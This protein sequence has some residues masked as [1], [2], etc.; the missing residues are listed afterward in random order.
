MTRPN[1]HGTA[2]AAK[3]AADSKEMVYTPQGSS[4]EIKLT[5]GIVQS[6]CCARTK[7]GAVATQADALKFMMLCQA[8]GLNPFEGDAYLV[9]YDGKNG[10]EFSMITAHQAF[11][12][13]AECHPEYDG[14]RSGVVVADGD[15]NAID[16]EGD[17]LFDDEVLL[18]GWATV[19]FKHRKY[20][21]YKR[22]SFRSRAK[23]N[24]FW[25]SDPAGMICKSA[26][27]DAL[28]ASF[29][30]LLGGLYIAEENRETLTLPAAETAPQVDLKPGTQKLMGT[31][32]QPA[33]R[34][35]PAADPVHEP[36][37]VADAE[38][39]DDA[40]QEPAEL[41]PEQQVAEDDAAGIYDQL[42]A[43]IAETTTKAGLTT[44][45]GDLKAALSVLGEARHKDLMSKYQARWAELSKQR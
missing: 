28:R 15:G 43:A 31:L 38:V 27:A 17:F 40:Q 1:G 32:K 26:E 4:K 13:R 16:R 2:N 25:N 30:T 23:D 34:P 45:G 41:T 6:L 11:L 24:K 14:M 3:P 10:P 42:K 29:P 22:L 35:T 20:P 36:E 19:Y 33:P 44:V 5:V 21:M 9:G 18:G 37:Q 12:K 8:R 39:V 7:S